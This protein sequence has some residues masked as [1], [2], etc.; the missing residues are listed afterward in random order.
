M[1]GEDRVDA[2]RGDLHAASVQGS[3]HYPGMVGGMNWGSVSIDAARGV[4][5]VNTMR[6]AT[7]VRLVPRAEFD[8][9]FP[10]EMHLPVAPWEPQAGT[11]YGLY[12]L[13]L[14]S[15]FGAPCNPPPWGTLVGID[16]GTGDKRWEVPLG[17]TR[18]LAP[19]PVWMFLDEGVPNLGGSIVTASGL[20]F[21]AATTDSYLRASTSR[22]ARSCGGAT[23]RSRVM[24]PPRPTG[25]A[26]MESSTS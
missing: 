25:C 5:V 17:T 21:I 11:P 15:P 14:L 4:M 19:W 12:R 18:G 9:L 2:F 10:D 26:R 6:V 13:P 8:K 23:C 1:S 20:A 24:R 7:E 3:V 16:I 22:P